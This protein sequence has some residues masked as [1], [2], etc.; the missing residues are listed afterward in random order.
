MPDQDRLIIQLID[1]V[2]TAVYGDSSLSN[3]R[4]RIID[5][6]VE[7]SDPNDERLQT[8]LEGSQHWTGWETVAPLPAYLDLD[9]LFKETP[10]A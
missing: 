1:G 8:D 2:V 5:Y 4:V 10:D 3:I 7:N 9:Q 6:D